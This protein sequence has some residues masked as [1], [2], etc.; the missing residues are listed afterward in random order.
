M[1]MQ[2]SAWVDHDRGADCPNACERGSHAGPR[3]RRRGINEERHSRSGCPLVVQ[4]S[5][6]V[7]SGSHGR[8]VLSKRQRRRCG[9]PLSRAAD[10][11]R[12][13]IWTGRPSRGGVSAWCKAGMSSQIATRAGMFSDQT[14]LVPNASALMS[15]SSCWVIVPLSFPSSSSSWLRL[16]SPCYVSKA[17][18]G[19]LSAA[20]VLRYGLRV[21]WC[22][23]VKASTRETGAKRLAVVTSTPRYADPAR[24]RP[25]KRQVKLVTVACQRVPAPC[26][27][28]QRSVRKKCQEREPRNTGG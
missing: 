19:G 5:Q 20:C 15:S 8:I 9:W 16:L 12:S 3:F 1:R 23:I 10:L 2:K 24:S 7:Q 21:C 14:G 13:G 26:G 17:R 11:A 18:I 4:G 6:L 28:R 25:I 22:P 27:G